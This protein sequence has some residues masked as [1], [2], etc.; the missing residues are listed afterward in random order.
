LFLAVLEPQES[1]V[2]HA[3]RSR[4]DVQASVYAG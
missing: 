3:K 1:I 4:D 2:D